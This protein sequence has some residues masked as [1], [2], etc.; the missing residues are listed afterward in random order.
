[1]AQLGFIGFGAMGGPMV[2]RLIAAGHGVRGCDLRAGRVELLAERGALPCKNPADTARGA[3]ALFL[4]LPGA[5]EVETALFGR[6]GAAEALE[7]GQVVAD[8]GTTPPA[9]T[10]KIAGRLAEMGVELVDAPVSGGPAG[11]EEGALTVMAGGELAAFEGILPYLETMAATVV[12]IGPSGHGQI[13]KIANQIV[14]AVNRE[15][16]AEALGFAGRAGAD[17]RLVRRALLGGLAQSRVLDLEGEAMVYSA[18]HPRYR[19]AHLRKD[20]ASV[21]AA[22]AE[23]GLTLPCT[24]TVNALY[25]LPAGQPA[26]RKGNGK[27]PEKAP[28]R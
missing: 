2:A 8:L 11:A 17:A 1:M 14:V 19:T 21:M 28:G 3:E 10:K 23:L 7:P 26:G 22:A 15:A 20:L 6:G 25:G 13:A 4:M 16:V 18:F 5:E 12:R 9:A 27:T 24:E